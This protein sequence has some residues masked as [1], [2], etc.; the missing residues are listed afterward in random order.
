MILKRWSMDLTWQEVDFSTSTIWVQIHGLPTLW[1]SEENLRR[2]GSKVGT[3]LE[4]D[5]T[6]DAGGAW[7]KFHR[8]RIELD[9]SYP[10]IPGIFLPRPNKCDLWIGLK[11][12][13]IADLCYQCGI[14]GHNLKNCSSEFFQLQNPVGYW[15]KAAGPWL[16]A[17][18]DEVPEGILMVPENNVPASSHIPSENCCSGDSCLSGEGSQNQ[19]LSNQ[20]NGPPQKFDTCSPSSDNYSGGGKDVA[21]SAGKDTSRNVAEILGKNVEQ[22]ATG[23]IPL[24]TQQVDRIDTNTAH[25]LIL[26]TPVKIGLNSANQKALVAQVQQKGPTFNQESSTYNKPTKPSPTMAPTP[27][28]PSLKSPKTTST[29]CNQIK[30]DHPDL[31]TQNQNSVPPPRNNLATFPLPHITTVNPP[32]S[33]QPQ[34][35]VLKRKVARPELDLFSKRLRKAVEGPEP[36]YFDPDTLSFIPESRLESFILEERR[37]TE[38]HGEFHSAFYPSSCSAGTALENVSS[39]TMAEEAGLIMPPTSP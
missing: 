38:N 9:V 8:V 21:D 1:R 2:I 36:V 37:K 39:V 19:L 3:V 15:F 32:P 5:L 18:N 20:T 14:I 30:S 16:R 11:Y 7:R 4:V 33:P 23:N 24:P 25:N 10:L 29:P 26:L 28:G 12:E 31:S 22:L 35:N 13:K 27:I 17:E 6:G 34:P